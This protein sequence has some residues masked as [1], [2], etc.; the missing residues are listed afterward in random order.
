MDPASA[1]VA[2]VG[3]AASIASLSALILDSC[4]K[5]H[6]IAQSLKNAP[7]HIRRLFS[8]VKRLHSVISEIEKIGNEIG[9]EPFGTDVQRDWMNISTTMRADLV[10][11][12]GKVSK[13]QKSL[14]GKSLSKVHMS[15]RVR[16]FFS[17]EEV[18]RYENLLSDHVET[19]NLFLSMLSK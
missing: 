19:I 2:F 7:N 8:K 14:D 11:F 10:A 18:D 1:A 9:D 12:E 17:A 16:M 15:V 4:N 5:I 3:F 13:L 6:S